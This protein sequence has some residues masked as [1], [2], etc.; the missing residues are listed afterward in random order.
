MS[1]HASG[2]SS[3][4][5]QSLQCYATPLFYEL[6]QE[7]AALTGISTSGLL[8]LALIDYIDRLQLR[9]GLAEEMRAEVKKRRT[10]LIAKT[11]VPAELHASQPSAA[12]EG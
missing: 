7:A 5:G 4:A 6:V 10:Y 8:R 2:G 9:A 1:R 12:A 11:P 3:T